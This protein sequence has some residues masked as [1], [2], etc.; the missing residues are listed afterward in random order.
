MSGSH[1]THGTSIFSVY[2]L[3]RGDNITSQFETFR[4]LCF[5]LVRKAIEVSLKQIFHTQGDKITIN[6]SKNTKLPNNQ[7]HHISN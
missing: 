5:E 1:L 6:P 2:F 7:P 3:Q 4:S